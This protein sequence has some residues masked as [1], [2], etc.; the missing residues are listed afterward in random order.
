MHTASASKLF[1]LAGMIT[2]TQHLSG[3]HICL[4]PQV[5]CFKL[6]SKLRLLA[7]ALLVFYFTGQPLGQCFYAHT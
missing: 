1:K 2:Y 6:F 3:L 7:F 4:C 5:F